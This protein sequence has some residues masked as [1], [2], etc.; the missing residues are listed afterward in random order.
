MKNYSAPYVTDPELRQVVTEIQ[1]AAGRPDPYAEFEYL[2]AEPKKVRGGMV[3]LADGTDWNPG[4]GVGPYR[5]SEDNTTWD[6]IGGG[7]GGG[8]T[9]TVTSVS[10][11]TANGFS[12]TVA[13]AT[14]TPAITMKATPVGVLK[15]NGTAI[16]AA[17][18]GTDY[19]TAGAGTAAVATHVGLADPHT[20]YALD[21]DLAGYVPTTRTVN[22]KPLSANVTLTAADVGAP[23]GSGTSSGTN[24]GDQFTATTASRL[25]GRG[26]ASAGAAQELTVG[27]GLSISGTTLSLASNELQLA[28][29][30]LGVAGTSLPSGTITACKFLRIEIYIAGYAGSD[31][32][33]LQF[34]GAAGTAYRYQWATMA[35][36]GTTFT[37]GLTAASTDRIKV[38]GVDTTNSRR[39]LAEVSNFS[40]VTEKI[41]VF[42][43]KTGTGSAATQA[44][45]NLGDGAWISAA[46]TQITSVSLV[47]SQPMNVGT[48]MTIYGWN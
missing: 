6:F 7:G 20:Q 31:T 29:V 5:R 13:T 40:T 1:E 8:G 10:V 39:I 30:T 2:H 33:S 27:T 42:M 19:E 14:T 3:V 21:T 41:V 34:N 17:T 12:A 46:A 16:S 48:Q 45:R 44:T 43:E 4:S 36:G 23:S 24:T 35:A 15:S 32:A 18:A 9:G 47:S 28:N 25:L 22:A 38:A 11:A 37:A 26:S